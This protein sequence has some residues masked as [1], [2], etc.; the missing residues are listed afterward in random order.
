MGPAFWVKTFGWQR[1]LGAV[2]TVCVRAHTGQRG[3]HRTG[4]RPTGRERAFRNHIHTHLGTHPTSSP[5]P[6]SSLH[7]PH[8]LHRHAPQHRPLRR[9]RYVAPHNA[10]APSNA[11]QTARALCLGAGR[12]NRKDVHADTLT[13]SR[14]FSSSARV[15]SYEDTIGN[16]YVS[17][18][19]LHKP[20]TRCGGDNA[21]IRRLTSARQGQQGPH[22]GLHRQDGTWCFPDHVDCN[23]HCLL[24]RAQ[25]TFHAQQS[26]AYGTRVIGGVNPKASTFPS[27]ERRE[28]QVGSWW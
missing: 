21:R 8:P 19:L 20:R 3:C 28:S 15:A 23:D 26:I 4:V 6:P 24:I 18:Y 16:I 11:L 22:P 17:E 7:H 1:R 14:Q 25:G 9:P 12:F 5:S 2:C 10:Q 27:E 13:A